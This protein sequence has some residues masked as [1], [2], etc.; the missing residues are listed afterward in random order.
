MFRTH[1]DNGFIWIHYYTKHAGRLEYIIHKHISPVFK[2]I[3]MKLFYH[4]KWR[5]A[6]FR[7]KVGGKDGREIT[8][9]DIQ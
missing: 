6:L 5:Q 9:A 1:R 4:L 2:I 8:P 7:R 3:R